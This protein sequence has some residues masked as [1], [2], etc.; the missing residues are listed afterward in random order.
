MSSAATLT[1]DAA[2]SRIG[3]G[4]FHYKL[5]ALCGWANA[6]D[7]IEMLGIS[8]IIT[9]LAE[10]D[11]D[12]TEARKGMVTAGLFI[13]MMLGG[14]L[15]GSLADKLGRK[16]TLILALLF[17][18]L[19]GFSSSLAT[20]YH[21]FLFFRIMS[22]L[23]VG[24]SIPIV[25]TYTTEFLP[26]KQR[27][28]YLSIVAAFWMVGTILVAGMAWGIIGAHECSHANMPSS[29]LLRCEEWD[30]S[31]CGYFATST[32]GRLPAWRLFVGLCSLPSLLAAVSI[33]FLPESPKWLATV[34]RIRQAERILERIAKANSSSRRGYSAVHDDDAKF[35]LSSTD[36]HEATP[37]QHHQPQPSSSS[38]SPSSSSSPASPLALS[39]SEERT[40]RHTM[41]WPM[42]ILSSVRNVFESTA[43][44]FR[45]PS[46]RPTLVLGGIWFFLSMGFYGLTLWL[47]NYFQHGAID[48]STSVYKVSFWVALANIP[49]NAFAFWG[50]DWL[51]RRKTLLI[52]M[53][54]SAASVFSILK[55]HSTAGTTAF[56][57]VFSGVSVAGWN[58]LNILS[59]ELYTT[60]QRG[61]AFG[62]LAATGRI[63]AIV[64]NMAFGAMSASSPTLPLMLTGAALAFGACMSL[65]VPETRNISIE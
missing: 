56:S 3:T 6:S 28:L 63:G 35:S 33:A 25:F 42:R 10:C 22:G 18:S 65:L 54:A 52:S 11:L 1:F 34:G 14:W 64:G 50:V 55:I 43:R 62:L 17:N 53:L 21:S 40:Q 32:G 29:I 44:L 8:F 51:G 30:N 4:W 60:R 57:C 59:A 61:A 2:I 9:T 19:F 47:P 23:G 7:A 48:A 31:G 37:P 5:V 38:P 24:G 36:T 16:Y 49:G 46:L 58:A 15:W 13:G 20:S 27:G 41:P 45:G 12:L 39:I 26:T